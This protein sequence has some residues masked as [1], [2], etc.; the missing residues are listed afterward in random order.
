MARLSDE[1]FRVDGTLLE[2]CASLKSFKW[3]GESKQN[4]PDDPGK[5][6]VNFHGE[7]RPNDTHASTTDPDAMLA[8]KGSGKETRLRY[9]GHVLMENRNGLL[10]EV[11]VLP[12]SGTAERDAGLIMIESIP[13]DRPVTVAADR[14]YGTKDFVAEC[15]HM[16]ATPHVAQKRNSAIDGRTTR[17]AGY[18][19]SQ[20]KRKLVEDILGWIKTI[21]G[22]RMLRH[23]GLQLASRLDVHL[24][25]RRIQSDSHPQ[26]DSGSCRS[27]HMRS[28]VSTRLVKGRKRTG[29]ALNSRNSPPIAHAS[30]PQPVFA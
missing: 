9:T 16:N 20:R 13:G 7:S 21:G 30:Q 1:H 10:T 5:P 22:M 17:H 23:R 18:A 14:S 8:R 4:A 12:A 11:E 24:Y 26:S 6:T 19:V 2:A 29:K 3:V 27:E 28:S 25:R 15:R